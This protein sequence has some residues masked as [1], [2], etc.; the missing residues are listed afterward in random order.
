MNQENKA[1]EDNT[2]NPPASEKSPT[3][4]ADTQKKEHTEN[5]KPKSDS[6]NKTE[7]DKP[8]P[9]DN[10]QQANPQTNPV[11]KE[12]TDIKREPTLIKEPITLSLLAQRL[13]KEPLDVTHSVTRNSKLP[14]AALLSLTIGAFALLGLIFGMFSG[15]HQLWAAP[16]KIAGGITFAAIICLPSLFIFTCLCKADVKLKTII[17]ILTCAICIVSLLL[18]GFIPILWLF[19]TTSGSVV[20]FG[21]LALCTWIICLSIGLSFINK[22]IRYLGAKS[23]FPLTVWFLI[24]SLVTLQ[25]PTTL[26]PIIGETEE[27]FINLKEK[28]FFLNHWTD[29]MFKDDF[30]SRDFHR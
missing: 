25:L 18:L 20:F 2:P 10:T 13:L 7:E 21:F 9:P 23:T 1:T 8:S 28:K 17:A 29:L 5:S 22:S 15:G 16:A 19:S 24:F 12:A 3:Q 30:D 4:E 27:D 14:W 26:R 11:K 6:P